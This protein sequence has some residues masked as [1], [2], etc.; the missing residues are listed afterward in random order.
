MAKKM[1]K[2]TMVKSLIASKEVHREN[3]EALG[4]SKLHAF[5]VKPDTADVRGMIHKVQHLV[6]VEE[7]ESEGDE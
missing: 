5:V 7:F 6:T 2:I 3:M 4:L 1:L